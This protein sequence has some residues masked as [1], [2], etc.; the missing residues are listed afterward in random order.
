MNAFPFANAEWERVKDA[1]HPVVQARLEDDDA[2][3]ES[4]FI[5]L[6]ETL[7]ELRCKYGEHPVLLETE[8][9]FCDD[10]DDAIPLYAKALN[11]AQQNS[12]P[13]VSI[14]LSYAH[15]L[16]EQRKV[17]EAMIVLESCREQVY[18]DGDL[19]EREDYEELT[20]LLSS[21]NRDPI[22]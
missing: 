3:G 6:Q 12:L 9:D 22:R 11:L 2:V 13:T 18:A 10:P 21:R 20:T 7:H 1:A 8:A 4:M 17:E 19:S 16:D 5:R 14:C 15:S